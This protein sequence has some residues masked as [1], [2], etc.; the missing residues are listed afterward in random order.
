MLRCSRVLTTAM[1][2]LLMSPV[3]FAQYGGAAVVALNGDGAAIVLKQPF[4]LVEKTVDVTP[5][6]D[7]TSVTRR[8]ELRKWRD[9]QGRFRQETAQVAEGK[10]AIYDRATITDPVKNTVTTLFLDRKTASIVHLPPGAL[11]PYVDLEDR[12]M[13][14]MPGVQIKIAKLD[15]KLIAGQTAVGR[16]V[17]R[18]RPP[19]TIGNATTIVSVSERWI[20]PDLKITLATSLDDPREKQTREV[21][22]LTRGEPD[23]SLFQVPADYTVTEATGGPLHEEI[24]SRTPR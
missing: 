10:D 20:S 5:K 19:G 2:V 7:G 15:N 17:T 24:I 16:R 4:T 9:S 23:A 13:A 11:H 21:T 14:A 8:T 12:P 3:A 6:A 1:V 18:T 22:E